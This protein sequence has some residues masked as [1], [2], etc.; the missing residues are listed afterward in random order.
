MTQD[1]QSNYQA[2]REA[3]WP[4][5]AWAGVGLVN[6]LSAGVSFGHGNLALGLVQGAAFAGSAVASGVFQRDRVAKEREA[7][8]RDM[9]VSTWSRLH[10][11]PDRHGAGATSRT[12]RGRALG[13]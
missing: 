12:G 9:S 3:R 5:V 13:R 7:N 11:D 10:A 2:R 8:A 1:R 4:E 6:A